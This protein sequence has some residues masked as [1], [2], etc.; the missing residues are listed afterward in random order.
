MTEDKRLLFWHAFKKEWA[1]YSTIKVSSDLKD[2]MTLL[3]ALSQI[4]NKFTASCGNTPRKPLNVL[5]YNNVDL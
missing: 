4:V 2:A 5:N 1:R 3:V